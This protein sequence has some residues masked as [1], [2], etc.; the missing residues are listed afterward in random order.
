MKIGQE[1]S[2]TF[3]D[4]AQAL[5]DDVLGDRAEIVKE[6][7]RA[8]YDALLHPIEADPHPETMES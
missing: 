4:F 8:R 1:G 3:A 5:I 6:R 2:L 7:E